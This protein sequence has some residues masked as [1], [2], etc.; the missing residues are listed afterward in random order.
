[1]VVDE[2][3]A[4]LGYEV[5]GEEK[6]RSFTR[7]IDQAAARLVKFAATTATIA[8]TA[9]SAFG[10]SV[11]DTSSMFEG[12]ETSLT[13]IEGSAE[14]ARES[15]DWITKFAVKT[16]YELDGITASFIKLKSYGIDPVNGI[17]ETLG[18]TASAMNKPLNQAVE[19]FADASTFQFERLREFGL[20]ANQKGEE[21]TFQWT[22]NGEKLTRVVKK[23]GAEIQKFLL[24]HFGNSFS[25]A[26]LRQS[27]TWNGMVSNIGDAWMVFQK[28][29]GDKGFFDNVK[30]R[31]AGLLDY[32]GELDADGTLDKW[33]TSISDGLV[34]AVDGAVFVMS[35]LQRHFEFL[36]GWVST[37]P[38]LWKKIAAGLGLLAAVVFPK[39]AAILVLEDVLTYLEG[40]DSVIGSI[41]ESLSQITGIEAGGLGDVLASL[42]AA[43]G[44]FFLFGGSFG[45][46]AKGLVAIGAALKGL[47]GAELV[48]DLTA[49]GTS[50]GSAYGAAFGV[51]AK[52]AIIAAVVLALEYFDPKGNLG[53][54]TTPV[55]NAIR[56]GLGLPEK[57]TGV[58]PGEI[59][60]GI[61]NL[62]TPDPVDAPE[63]DADGN[64]PLRPKTSAVDSNQSSVDRMLAGMNRL[65]SKSE[66]DAD[67]NIPLRPD[68]GIA[69]LQGIVANAKA[70]SAKASADNSAAVVSNTVN[71]TSDRSV[72]VNVGGVNVQQ[73]TQAPAAV[74]AA[75]GNAAAK[76]AKSTNLPPTRI[77]GTGAL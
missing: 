72:T 7:S 54:L 19:A 24:E 48:K 45:T 55:D 62:L 39:G 63:A 41:A 60:D 22:K 76:A 31:L 21:V 64:I 75:V 6:L 14:K 28:R 56:S 29:V 57:D 8:A 53:G 23:D 32:I 44:T 46:V 30:E 18:D 58:T 67:G 73:S 59:I 65:M 16:P 43:A 11:I 47:A 9:M 4:I 33:A 17:L 40:G 42:A 25:G 2:L 52:A 35:R 50:A 26:M 15:M 36:S 68:Q 74:G 61:G 1:M 13:T 20:V 10:K 71:D 34:S 70:N 66:P 69:E 37:N 38:D 5:K 12:F 49:M 77:S 51:A 3:I 27:K